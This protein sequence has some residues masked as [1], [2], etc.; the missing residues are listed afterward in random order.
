MVPLE[1]ELFT[2]SLW[3]ESESASAPPFEG[4]SSRVENV[5]VEAVTDDGENSENSTVP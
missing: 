5:S 1:A 3:S 4:D 2:V